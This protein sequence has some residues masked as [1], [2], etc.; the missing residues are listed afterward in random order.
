MDSF[1]FPLSPTVLIIDCE[2]FEEEV[3]K[4]WAEDALRRV[5]YGLLLHKLHDVLK[6]NVTDKEIDDEIDKI[7][8]QNPNLDKNRLKEYIY[9]VIRNDKVFKL[10]C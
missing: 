9:G 5:S 4:G 6:I 10:L 8:A 1:N 7:R 2:G 3:L